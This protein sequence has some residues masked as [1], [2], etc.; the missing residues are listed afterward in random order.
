MNTPDRNSR[1]QKA[2]EAYLFACELELMAFKPGNVSV[3]SE[4]HD[5][6]V[7]DFR[8]SARVSAGPLCD[9][10][11]SLGER[12]F[13]AALAT[14]DAVGCNTN[15]GILLLAAPLI[16]AFERQEP[17]QSLR[18]ALANLLNS[19]TRM[20]ADHVYRAIRVAQP[21]GLGEVSDQDVS[22]T[23]E[24][25]LLDAMR[26]SE[27]RDSI[28]RQYTSSYKD[29]F[30]IAIPLYHERLSQWDNDEE[31]ATVAVFAGVLRLIPDS[32][33]ER[34]FGSRY[35]AR[36]THR[37]TQIHEALSGQETPFHAMPLLRDVDAEFKSCGI[38]PGTTAD[39]VVA[40]VLAA[41]L[42]GHRD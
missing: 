24:V 12:I 38:N 6:T 3:Y 16:C 30:E 17:R 35:N 39:L 33:I 40:C 18:E 10:S 15:L 42:D 19:T 14:R 29:V 32:H 1:R 5:M 20:D 37:M 4:G 28:A 13:R 23:P 21:G 9:P 36:V 11:L 41:C 7:G 34:K 8:Q 26:L 22:E 27:C 2:R 25:T 31:W